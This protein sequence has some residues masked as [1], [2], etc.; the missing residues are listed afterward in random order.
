MSHEKYRR[1]PPMNPPGEIPGFE[2]V[3]RKKLPG[4]RKTAAYLHLTT[5]II[6]QFVREGKFQRGFSGEEEE[7]L[8]DY[9]S[10]ENNLDSEAGLLFLES[11]D[12]FRPVTI[13]PIESFLLAVH[14]LTHTQIRDLLGESAPSQTGDMD[15]C[16]TLN[17]S[18]EVV[19]ALED[20]GLRLPTESEWE[21]V[22][23][24][25]SDTPF[26]WGVNPPESPLVPKNPFGFE[27]MGEFGELCSDSWKAGYDNTAPGGSDRSAGKISRV[28]RGGSA[29]VWPWQNVGEWLTMLSAYRS[30]DTGHDGFIKIR[31]AYNL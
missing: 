9:L 5:S 26:P 16:L 12:A 30:P 4:G 25:G 3:S 2:T 21:Y 20:T 7:A 6:F 27:G 31:P 15:E 19:A 14:P 8:R 24:A 11:L 18:E 17:V 23:R 28:V 13:V 1:I 29:E 22:Y 10:L